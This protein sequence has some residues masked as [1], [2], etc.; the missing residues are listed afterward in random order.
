MTYN[1]RMPITGFKLA[2]TITPCNS[3]IYT[4]HA[5]DLRAG[6]PGHENDS[7]GIT[8]SLWRSW[9]TRRIGC[10]PQSLDARAGGHDLSS[11]MDRSRRTHVA[12]NTSSAAN[13]AWC[14]RSTG[15]IHS[16]PEQIQYD[17][18]RDRTACARCGSTPKLGIKGSQE[19]SRATAR[20]SPHPGLRRRYRGEAPEAQDGVTR[21]AA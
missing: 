18:E 4:P 1:S 16:T 21:A 17:L 7:G 13:S 6:P 10:V 8:L 19:V 14:S 9:G 11:R 3:M 2:R 20:A 12:G 15:P 5:S